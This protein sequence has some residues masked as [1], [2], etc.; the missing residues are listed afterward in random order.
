M[1]KASGLLSSNL[2]ANLKAAPHLRLLLEL[3][4]A[5]RVF[6]HN[7]AD[8]L[9]CRSVPPIATTS[10]PAPFWSDVFVYSGVSWWRLLDSVLWHLLAVAVVW[11]LSHCALRAQPQ[12]RRTFH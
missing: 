2:N 12:Q 3:E 6:F 8:T 11:S 5:H 7:L 9:L 1:D 4:P 10:S